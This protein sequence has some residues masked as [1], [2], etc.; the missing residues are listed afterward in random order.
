MLLQEKMQQTEFSAA[1][2]SL[3]AFLLEHPRAIKTETIKE[4]SA[5]TFVH[6][7]TFIRVA[8]KLGFS[9]WLELK[10]AFLEEQ[11]YMNSHFENV[12]ANLPFQRQDGILTIAKKLANLEQTT[13]TDTLSLLHHNSLQQA[14][15]LLLQAKQIKI[16]ASNANT[17][18]SQDFV[19]KMRRI[20]KNVIVCDTVGEHAYEA[21]NS[22]GE[23]C[24]LLISYTGEN[25]VISEVAHILVKK[26]VPFIGITSIG[27]NTLAALASCVLR[28]TTRERLYS[29]IG[30]FT[31]NTSICY[32][33]NVLYGAVFSEHYQ[34]NLESLIKIGTAYDNRPSSSSIMAEPLVEQDSLLQSDALFPN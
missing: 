30:N 13:I 19:L 33:L 32:L 14:K 24:A 34:E 27:D 4:I 8:K 18:I 6:P 26:N 28:I 15:Q 5:K 11:Q 31:I 1:E 29:K 20:H 17:L 16:F 25:Q 10:A 9:G 7:S 12:D 2:K 3:I 21:A 22:D 23:T